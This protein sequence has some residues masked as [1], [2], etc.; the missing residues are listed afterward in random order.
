MTDPFRAVLA[1]RRP[2][3]PWSAQDVTGVALLST[4]GVAMVGASWWHTASLAD[5]FDQLPWLALGVAGVVAAG[6][7]NLR[8]ILSGRRAIGAR[9]G[10]IVVDLAEQRSTAARPRAARAAPSPAELVAGPTMSSFHRPDCQL[11]AGKPVDAALP[12]VHVDAGRS[13]CRVCQP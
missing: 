1:Q 4:V 10:S 8:W 6:A 11:V 2:A 13:P 9:T 5:P 7:A 3:G 12:E